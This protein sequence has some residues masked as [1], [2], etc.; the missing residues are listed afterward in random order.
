MAEQLLRPP[1]EIEDAVKRIRD[2]VDNTYV[3]YQLFA[4]TPQLPISAGF[5]REIRKDLKHGVMQLVRKAP[6]SSRPF[7]AAW[8]LRLADLSCSVFKN[9][10]T[11]RQSR[12]AAGF[13]SRFQDKDPEVRGLFMHLKQYVG[14]DQVSD[15]RQFGCVLISLRDKL[16]LPLWLHLATRQRVNGR[17]VLKQ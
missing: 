9:R 15:P 11:T 14:R 4:D 8:R 6:V 3:L 10:L 17:W 16:K 7:L 1:A 5:Y 2:A 13:L 12:L